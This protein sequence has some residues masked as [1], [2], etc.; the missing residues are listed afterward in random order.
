M[1]STSPVKLS[2]PTN[3]QP[4][5]YRPDVLTVTQPTVSKTLK[6]ELLTMAADGECCA[7]VEPCYKCLRGASECPR[8]S[9]LSEAS[10]PAARRRVELRCY[11]DADP[12]CSRP[13]QVLRLRGV[14]G[15]RGCRQAGAGHLSQGPR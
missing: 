5:F 8:G 1:R 7:C 15:G 9:R 2:P 14:V 12:P 10:R 4:V 11:A 13:R 6:G 3:R